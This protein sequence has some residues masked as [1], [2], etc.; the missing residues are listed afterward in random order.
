MKTDDVPAGRF[1]KQHLFETEIFSNIL[2]VFTVSFDR[3]SAPLLNK[4]RKKCLLTPNA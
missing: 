1:D 2:K 3:F 4:S